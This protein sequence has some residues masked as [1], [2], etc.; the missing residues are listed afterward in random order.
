MKKYLVSVLTIVLCISVLGTSALAFSF[1]PLDKDDVFTEEILERED[2]SSWAVDEVEAAYTAGLIPNF[3]G[4]PAFKDTITREQFAE[5]IV[6][7]VTAICGEAPELDA[8]LF[9]TDCDNPSVMLA[10]SAGIVNGVGNNKFDPN[11][12]TNR[13]QIATMLYR[14][15][16]YIEEQTG[17]NPASKAGGIAKYTDKDA[18]SAWAV[19]GVGV[20]AA[21]G[22]MKGTSDTTLSPKSPCTVEQSIILVYRLYMEYVTN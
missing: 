3:T 19:E 15:I 10:A 22:I 5:L 4:A 16:G 1:T 2:V 8:S 20:L 6:R 14:A 17:K 21:N 7:T 18:V 11:A 12:T 9:F 13:E